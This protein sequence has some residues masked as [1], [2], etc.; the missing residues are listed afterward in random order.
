MGGVL[1]VRPAGGSVSYGTFRFFLVSLFSLLVCFFVTLFLCLFALFYTL[2]SVFVCACLALL[3]IQFAL[4]PLGG[5]VVLVLVRTKA[6][7][8]KSALER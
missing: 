4:D 7:N 6:R 2:V 8:G 3:S 1:G 5:R